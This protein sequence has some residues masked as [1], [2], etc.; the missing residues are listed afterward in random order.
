ME[1]KNKTQYSGLEERP[2]FQNNDKHDKRESMA[3]P[4]MSLAPFEIL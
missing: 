3:T 1:G 2:S 4:S